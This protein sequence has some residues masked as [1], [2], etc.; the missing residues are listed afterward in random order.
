MKTITVNI[1]KKYYN[2]GLGDIKLSSTYF[3]LVLKIVQSEN[4]IYLFQCCDWLVFGYRFYTHTQNRPIITCTQNGPI[5]TMKH[6][7]AAF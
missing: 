5:R 1:K 6:I 4:C 2:S 7:Y 3:V